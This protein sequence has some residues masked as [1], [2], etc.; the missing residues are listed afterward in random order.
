MV[1]IYNHLILQFFSSK[2]PN[3]THRPDE[4]HPDEIVVPVGGGRE[5]LCI[6]VI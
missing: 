4:R 2:S 5:E 1:L 6:A 3:I